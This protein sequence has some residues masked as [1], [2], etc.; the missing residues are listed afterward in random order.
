M[1]I[2]L[3]KMLRSLLFLV[4]LL[5]YTELVYAVPTFGEF[6]ERQGAVML[7]MDPVTGKIVRA[8]RAAENFYGYSRDELKKMSIQDLNTLTPK[9][10]SKELALARE[11]KRNYFIFHHRLAGGQTRQVAVHSIPYSFDNQ[12]F[13]VSTIHELSSGS[14]QQQDLQHYQ[15]NLEE[16]LQLQETELK[17]SQER[18]S[19]ILVLAVFTQAI[20]ILFLFYDISRRKQLQAELKQVATTL[21]NIMDSST[22]VAVIA[23]DTEGVITEF[24]SGAEK[25]LGYSAQELVGKETPLK[26]HSEKEI[27]A[28]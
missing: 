10:V 11:E 3:K 27:Q 13:L 25:L 1:I 4:A 9:Q 6:F 7:I 18:Q 12:S 17:E 22:E 21:T 14:H 5:G 26:F 15:Q 24:N 23:T 20:L 19:L 2:S 16:L 28:R 8:N